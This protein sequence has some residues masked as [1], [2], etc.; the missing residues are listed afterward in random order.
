LV[1]ALVAFSV[2]DALAAVAVDVVVAADVVVDAVDNKN[3]AID[4][5]SALAGTFLV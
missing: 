3:R 2:L 5:V 4:T 1:L